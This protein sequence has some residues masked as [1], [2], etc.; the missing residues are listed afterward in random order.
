[1][2][3]SVPR[4]AFLT[5]LALLLTVTSGVQAQ[6]PMELPPLAGDTSSAAQSIN[7]RGEVAGTSSGGSNGSR[8]VVW[9]SEGTIIRVLP[10]LEGDVQSRFA[11]F[12]SNVI[13]NHG[14]V[15]GASIASDTTTTPVVWDHR[16]MPKALSLLPG[17]DG[18]EAYSISAHGRIV[19]ES[20]TICCIAVVVWDQKGRPTEI[21]VGAP[22]VDFVVGSSIN[23]RTEIA[24]S[25]TP[26]ES[27]TSAVVWDRKGVREEL[28]PL[29]VDQSCGASAINDRGQVAGNC[30]CVQFGPVN[31]ACNVDDPQTAVVWDPKGRPAALPPLPGDEESLA[32]GIN[33]RGQIVGQ[34][35]NSSGNEAAV[36]W[37]RD[38]TP[39]ALPALFGLP[40]CTAQG[41]NA[42]GQVVGRCIVSTDPFT[43]IAVLWR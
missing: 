40:R 9:N 11:F 32:N 19:G 2:Q 20:S 10:P 17:D 8:A 22:D 16:G 6:T 29:E 43:S 25:S 27:A 15:V 12:S 38:G 1:M 35:L 41:I 33:G 3:P 21:A 13:N 42:R 34:S 26:A 24:G 37:D 14:Q 36:I 18:G 30:A 5:V 7:D 23:S 28:P 31:V 4:L 39:T